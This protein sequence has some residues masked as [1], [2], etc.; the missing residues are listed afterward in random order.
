MEAFSLQ[1]N[2]KVDQDLIENGIWRGQMPSSSVGSEDWHAFLRASEH[3]PSD[4]YAKEAN[5]RRTLNRFVLEVISPAEALLQPSS[6]DSLYCQSEN[7]NP[8]LGGIARHYEQGAVACLNNIVL[9]EIFSAFALSLCRIASFSTAIR[10]FCINVH[11][12]RYSASAGSPARNS[13]PGYHKD[14]ERFISVHLLDRRNLLGGMNR[15]ADNKR[16][17]IAEFTLQEPGECFLID[18]EKVWHSVD[19]MTIAPGATLGTRDILLI[20]YLPTAT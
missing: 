6:S 16:K 10:K 12:I 18:D 2:V 20:D 5:R 19:E 14:G 4:L 17:E 1:N 8:E 11:H 7:Y 13:P 9:Q 3:L 15:I